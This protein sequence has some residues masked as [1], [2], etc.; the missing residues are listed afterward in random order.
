M[1]KIELKQQC[2]T[3]IV[4]RLN[5]F[6]GPLGHA[7][8]ARSHLY[9][10][11]ICGQVRLLAMAALKPHTAITSSNRAGQTALNMSALSAKATNFVRR[12]ELTQTAKRTHAP[13]EMA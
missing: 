7:I 3:S 8:K 12:N 2:R 9:S 5:A 4:V 11:S 1:R 6:G 13:Q 10:C